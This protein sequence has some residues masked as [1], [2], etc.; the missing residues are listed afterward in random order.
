MV[1]G[2]NAPQSGNPGYLTGQT[3]TRNDPLPQQLTQPQDMATL[4]SPDNTFPM[5]KHSPQKQ[6][7]DSGNPINRLAEATAGTAPQQRP[8]TPS[9]LL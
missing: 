5:V 4:I 8:Q 3:Q 9:V 1:T 2:R 7:S 6:N